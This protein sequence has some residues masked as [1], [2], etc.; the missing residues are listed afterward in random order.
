MNF[1]LSD[2]QRLLQES[3]ARFVAD[4]YDLDKRN[5][6]VAK[7]PGFG[8]DHWRQFAEL[9]WLALPFCEEDGGIGG[10]AIDV[11]LLLEQLGKGLVVEPYLANV[12]LAGG[13]LRRAAN[14]QQR[15]EQLPSAR[16]R[17]P[18]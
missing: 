12:V 10:T 15:A 5:A 18:R 1:D 7:E 14:A 6:L 16:L 2:E 9:G 17:V 11:M 13:V 8:A 4:Q 3:V